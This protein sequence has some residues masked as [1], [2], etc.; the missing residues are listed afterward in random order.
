MLNHRNARGEGGDNEVEGLRACGR[1]F[2]IEKDEQAA[3]VAGIVE[4]FCSWK[5]AAKRLG[6]SARDIALFEPVFEERLHA[7]REAF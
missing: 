7:L 5:P 6:C 4:A 3:C 2:D 1:L